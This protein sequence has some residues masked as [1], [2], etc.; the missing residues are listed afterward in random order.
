MKDVGLLVLRL[1]TGG[2]LAGHGS[3]KLFGWFKGY[4]PQG[5]AGWLES[6]QMKPGDQWAYLAGASEFSGGLLT[7][8]GFMSPVG[9]IVA[10]A[11]MAIATGKVHWGKPIWVS[12]GGAE[13]PITNI[14]VLTALSFTGPGRLSLDRAFRIRLPWSLIAAAAALTTFGIVRGLRGQPPVPQ[15]IPLPE[16]AR[17]RLAPAGLSSRPQAQPV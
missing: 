13:L 9:S 16:P 10:T 6:M 12:E 8:L 7:A 14:A 11:P 3:Q 2:L 17:R 5:T 4:G 15:E 1:V